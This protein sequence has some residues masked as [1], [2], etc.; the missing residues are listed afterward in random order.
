MID[1]SQQYQIDSIDFQPHDLVILPLHQQ[2]GSITNFITVSFS[3][4]RKI[5]MRTP[6]KYQWVFDYAKIIYV[7]EEM[8]CLSRPISAL[9]RCRVYLMPSEHGSPV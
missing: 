7:D 9:T 4:D 5:S 2:R 6:I 8:K 3:P 1:L